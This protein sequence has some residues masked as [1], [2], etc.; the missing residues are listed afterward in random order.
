MIEHM[1]VAEQSEVFLANL[2]SRRRRPAKPAT[3]A[4]YR[5]YIQTWI[6]PCLGHMDLVDI[7]NA[8]MK[9][10]VSRLVA[11]DLKPSTICG[12]TTALKLLVASDVDENGNERYPRKWNPD[13][14]DAPQ[15]VQ[16]AQDAPII[17]ARGVSK[18]IKG[19]E[20][21]FPCLYALLAGTGLRISEA[22]AL[23]MGPAGETA[24][25]WDPE[26]AV[27]YVRQAVYRGRY[28]ETKT[29]SGVRQVDI[30]GELNQYLHDRLKKSPGEL[31][32][33]ARTGSPASLGTCYAKAEI[34]KIPGF[35]SLRRFRVT[36]LEGEGVPNTLTKYWIGHASPGDMTARYAKVGQDIEL[37]KKWCEKAGLGFELPMEII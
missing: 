37:R 16:T 8:T 11:C 28:Q 17:T 26:A 12:V 27:I 35:H 32:F 19:A 10:F 36:H 33:T 30:F 2:Q 22:L 31:L 3:I 5:S 6:K 9:K 20:G 21:Y 25:I 24:S 15:L 18:A 14:I 1:N 13:F 34:D 23:R 7:E 29:P 4:A